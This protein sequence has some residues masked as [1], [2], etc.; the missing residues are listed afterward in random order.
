MRK[1]ILLWLAVL[2]GGAV[3]IF[4]LWTSVHS[5][6]G[7]TITLADGTRVTYLGATYGRKHSVTEWRLQWAWPPL[8]RSVHRLDT[9]ADELRLWFRAEGNPTPLLPYVRS[10]VFAPDGKYFGFPQTVT[11]DELLSGD[12]IAI[13]TYQY[14][15]LRP[16]GQ[17]VKVHFWEVD[18]QSHK[19]KLSSASFSIRLPR[20]SE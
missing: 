5:W 14:K 12:S 9:P 16:E 19:S 20:R 18:L 3:A 17:T 8:Q 4:A 15:G 10:D 13:T 1:R 11:M 7:R 2:I 6:R